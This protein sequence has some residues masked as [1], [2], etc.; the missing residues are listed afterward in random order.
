[1]NTLL[2]EAVSTPVLLLESSGVIIAANHSFLAMAHVVRDHVVGKSLFEICTSFMDHSTVRVFLDRAIAGEDSVFEWKIARDDSMR[3]YELRLHK[4]VLDAGRL[5]IGV[6]FLDISDQKHQQEFLRSSRDYYLK[7]FDDFPALVW[8]AGTDMLCDYFN[9][10]WMAFTG[11]SLETEIGN[12]WAD[13]IHSEDMERCLKKYTES[14]AA[15]KSFMMDYRLRYHDGS[16]RWIRDFGQPIHTL[17][18][19]FAGYLGA[20]FDLNELKESQDKVHAILREKD[21][22]LRETHHRIKN[23]MATISALLGMQAS[24]AQDQHSFMAFEEART[25]IQGMMRLYDLLYQGNAGELI[26]FPVY[27]QEL[28]GFIQHYVVLRPEHIRIECDVQDVPVKADKAYLVGILVNELVSNA[29]KYAFPG[30][31]KGV[32]KIQVQVLG[33]S[34]L[35]K[36][37]DNGVG[38]AASQPTV[39]VPVAGSHGFGMELVH[40]VCQQLKAQIDGPG[41]PGTIWSFLVPLDV[42]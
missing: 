16:Y 34:W 3:H 33:N 5:C 13:G 26:A 32:I 1:M 8:R 42:N 38:Y 4:V 11:R 27:M 10:E 12:G 18:G 20:C 30:D 35:L 7:L 41:G 36:V 14:F 9:Q 29:L 24:G 40:L 23:N 37:S 21:L 2:L 6:T 31:A 28:V 17:E 25:R 19:K 22:L 15:R 39:Q